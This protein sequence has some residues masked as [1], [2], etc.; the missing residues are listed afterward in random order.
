MVTIGL[1]HLTVA[2]YLQHRVA[3]SRTGG[4]TRALLAGSASLSCAPFSPLSRI[5]RKYPISFEAQRRSVHARGDF[6][7]V[8]YSSGHSALKTFD[9]HHLLRLPH[10]RA[11]RRRSFVSPLSTFVGLHGFVNSGGTCRCCRAVSRRRAS[12]NRVAT[13]CLSPSAKASSSWPSSM[14]TPSTPSTRSERLTSF[15]MVNIPQVVAPSCLLSTCLLFCPAHMRSPG[16]PKALP[17]SL[18]WALNK[19][20]VPVVAPLGRWWA[21][22]VPKAG[23]ELHTYVGRPVRLHSADLELK[24]CFRFF[25]PAFVCLQV[26]C[27]KTASGDLTT[28]VIDDYHKRSE[29]PQVFSSPWN[30]AKSLLSQVCFGT[31]P[32]LR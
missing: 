13:P 27:P 20:G 5:P 32:P 8:L 1:S 6:K 24:L 12:P 11:R 31:P 21:P 14:A 17:Y 28:A 10:K 23:S 7:L 22:L 19:W 15:R 9:S 16:V 2:A 3:F 26:F 29:A 25:T 18:R 4:E 30:L